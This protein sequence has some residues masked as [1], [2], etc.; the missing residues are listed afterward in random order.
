MLIYKT[1][2][3]IT[4]YTC[5]HSF[6]QITVVETRYLTFKKSLN[7]AEVKAKVVKKTLKLYFS[8]QTS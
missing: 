8:H 7:K 4:L 5:K 6:V 1:V 3:L 2:I